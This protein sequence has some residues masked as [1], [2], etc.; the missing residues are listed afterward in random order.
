MHGG[1][2]ASAIAICLAPSVAARLTSEGALVATPSISGLDW[3]PSPSNAR[4]RGQL[5]VQAAVHLTV[6]MTLAKFERVI[7]EAV[8]ASTHWRLKAADVQAQAY[9]WPC[10]RSRLQPASGCKLTPLIVR[11]TMSGL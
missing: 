9:R 2:G 10:P 7:R 8:A 1:E 11:V 4:M 5:I 6:S 3:K